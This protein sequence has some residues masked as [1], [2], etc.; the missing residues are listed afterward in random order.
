MSREG[1]AII[2]TRLESMLVLC[3]MAIW[4]SPRP[5]AMWQFTTALIVRY[6]VGCGCW[7]EHRREV[8]WGTGG[9]GDVIA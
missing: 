1:E 4:R 2:G 6:R 8:S 5:N 9:L 3:C 7:R